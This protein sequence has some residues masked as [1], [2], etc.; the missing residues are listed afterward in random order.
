MYRRLLARILRRRRGSLLSDERGASAIEFAL[1]LPVLVFA[2]MATVDL[3]L[4]LNQKLELDQSLRAGAQGLMAGDYDN[5][6]DATTKVKKLVETIDAEASAADANN[7]IETATNKIQVAVDRF[8]M[9]PEDL[10]TKVDCTAKVC[11][12][13]VKRYKFYQI[14]GQQNYDTMYLPA[15]I[16]LTGSILVQIE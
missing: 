6:P 7:Q 5:K 3:G 13:S 14:S 1:L 16:S 9:C 12:N 11:T 4:A 2:C 10:A 15:D 8:C